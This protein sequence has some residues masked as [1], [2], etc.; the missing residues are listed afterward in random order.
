MACFR[1]SNLVDVSSLEFAIAFPGSDLWIETHIKRSAELSSIRQFFVSDM[2]G[3]NGSSMN[4]HS[5][6]MAFVCHHG[7]ER[8]LQGFA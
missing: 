8:K 5:L 4:S 6:I 2:P 1:R 3:R 7:G